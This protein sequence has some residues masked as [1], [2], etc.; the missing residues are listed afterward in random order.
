[1][2]YSFEARMEAHDNRR[3]LTD[4][5]VHDAI[6]AIEKAINEAIKIGQFES[7]VFLGSFLNHFEDEIKTEIN[8]N[9]SMYGYKVEWRD[10]YAIVNYEEG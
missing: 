2:T 7:V 9:L 10:N 6:D 1:M 4:D 5:N 8:N 3:T